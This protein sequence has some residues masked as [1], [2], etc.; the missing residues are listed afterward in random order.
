MPPDQLGKLTRD[1]LARWD[2]LMKA[3]GIRPE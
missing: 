2:N 3:T 1:Q